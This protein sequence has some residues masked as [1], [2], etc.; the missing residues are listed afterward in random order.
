[1]KKVIDTQKTMMAFPSGVEIKAPKETNVDIEE[2]L[3]KRVEEVK[4]EQQQAEAKIYEEKEVTK[5]VYEDPA[6]R[7]ANAEGI[8][9]GLPSK[10]KFYKFKDLYTKSLTGFHMPKLARARSE[11]NSRL[12]AEVLGSV[13]STTDPKINDKELVFKL[14]VEDY[15]FLLYWHLMNS[16]AEPFITIRSYCIG[17]EHTSEVEQG[18]KP[19]SSLAISEKRRIEGLELRQ[20]EEP[21]DFKDYEELV[22]QPLQPCTVGDQLDWMEHPKFA[23]DEEFRYAGRYACFLNTGGR[24]TDRIEVFNTLSLQQ[25]S[26]LKEYSEK[27]SDYGINHKVEVTCKECGV[28]RREVILLDAHTFLSN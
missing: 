22:G 24:L 23:E 28:S 13:L 27:V 16:F 7:L 14:T 25:I 21:E 5:I 15:Y 26:Y 2:S 17:L 11:R 12:T 19:M 10:H 3:A 4:Q 20:F 1:M 18:K 8:L 9:L 6:P